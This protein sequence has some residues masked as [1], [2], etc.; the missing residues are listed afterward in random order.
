MIRRQG[1]AIAWRGRRGQPSRLVAA[2]G[3][4]LI[5]SI[6]REAELDFDPDTQ[7]VV[8]VMIVEKRK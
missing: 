6:K 3:G 8:R 1:W 5:Y 4:L 2:H 7:K